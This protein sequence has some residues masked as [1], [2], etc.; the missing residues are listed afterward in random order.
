MLIK[1]E[2]ALH[3]FAHAIQDFMMM[4]LMRL[5]FHVIIPVELAVDQDNQ[6]V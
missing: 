5:V 4:A 3:R 1:I 2:W 6:I